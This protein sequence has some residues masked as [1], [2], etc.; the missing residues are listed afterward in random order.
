MILNDHRGEL[1]RDTPGVIEKEPD[2]V[3]ARG[4]H[5]CEVGEGIGYAAGQPEQAVD[6]L[7]RVHLALDNLGKVVAPVDRRNTELA[8]R[9]SP[10]FAALQTR[11]RYGGMRPGL[12]ATPVNPAF[13]GGKV[14]G[15]RR[16]NSAPPRA[17]RLLTPEGRR[18]RDLFGTYRTAIRIASD[19]IARDRPFVNVG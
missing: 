5:L 4:G 18:A 7:R 19:W 12:A 14:P 15:P 6:L 9:S 8:H 2:V 16:G 1:C 11:D 10:M 17:C 3:L 13:R